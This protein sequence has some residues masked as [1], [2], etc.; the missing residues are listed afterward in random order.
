VIVENGLNVS[1]SPA[2][3]QLLKAV[4][5]GNALM[6]SSNKAAFF[7]W[8]YG[9]Q[10]G[11]YNNTITGTDQDT[12]VPVFAVPGVYY[13]VCIAETK[14]ETDTSNEIMI[15]VEPLLDVIISPSFS[16]YINTAISDTGIPLTAT[17]NLSRCTYQWK[18][19][20]MPG[21]YNNIISGEILEF[22]TPDTNTIKGAIPDTFYLV[23]VVARSI[24]TDTSNEIMV[25]IDYTTSNHTVDEELISVYPIPTS[26]IVNI[27]N[28]NNLKSI[29]VFNLAGDLVYMDAAKISI[30]LSSLSSGTYIMILN[31]TINRKIIIE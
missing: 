14:H 24:E 15:T 25:I 31:N 1:V 17:S 29:K 13:I 18:Y 23:C 5:S 9:S 2:D 21:V 7:H 3:N 26:G 27:G 20:S 10:S 6:A 22:Y 11:I 4:S 30:D 12:L 8:K 16:Q 28:I 19:G